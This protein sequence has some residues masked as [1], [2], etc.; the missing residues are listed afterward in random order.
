[1]EATPL[2]TKLAGGTVALKPIA[3]AQIEPAGGRGRQPRAHSVRL[4]LALSQL[5]P[6]LADRGRVIALAKDA[7]AQLSDHQPTSF[8]DVVGGKGNAIVGVEG[9]VV[10]ADRPGAAA[11]DRLCESLGAAGYNVAVRELRE[12]GEAVCTSSA[13]LDARRVEAVPPGWYAAQICGKHGYKSCAGCHSVYLMSSANASGQA[14]SL[15]CEVCGAIL[16]EWCG[17]KLWSAELLTRGDPP[18]S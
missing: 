15:H 6:Q 4:A 8:V 18:I 12:C 14:P 3:S 5:N 11:I 7:L 1:M 9:S 2:K 16:I 13:L 10:C 17:S